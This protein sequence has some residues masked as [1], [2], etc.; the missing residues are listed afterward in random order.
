MPYQPQSIDTS[1]EVDRRLFDLYRHL[2]PGERAERVRSLC[3]TADALA[4]A[5]LRTRDPQASLAQCRARLMRRR[6]RALMAGDHPLPPEVE[7][8]ANIDQ[9][10]DPFA[11][12]LRLT[13]G[14]F[15]VIGIPWLIGGSIASSVHGEP[16]FTEDIDLAAD[17][18]EEHI[19]ALIARLAEFHV[20]EQQLR[21]AVR[22]GS[23]FSLIHVASVQKVD[24]FVIGVEALGRSELARRQTIEVGSGVPLTLQVASPEDVVLQKLIWYRKGRG[25]SERQWRDVLGVLK[26]QAERLDLAYLRAWAAR[27]EIEDLLDRALDEAGV[28]D[29]K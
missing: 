8:M 5:G 15:D 21:H 7:S 27:S 24:V 25:V 16:R 1:V 11:A 22:S 23:S 12:V 17:V 3:R 19:E 4:I 14:V 6:L 18:R 13:V 9:A 28:H 10:L 26:V 29:G 20:P 2:S